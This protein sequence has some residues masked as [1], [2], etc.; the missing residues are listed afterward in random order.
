MRNV[1]EFIRRNWIR[2][3]V[4]LA[5]G[6]L[7]LLANLI[8]QT[9]NGSWSHLVFY[10]DGTF[11]GGA[12][13]I[14]FSLL[15]V[16]NIFGAFDIFSY[17]FARKRLE[18]GRKEDLYEYS[19]RKKEQRS[20]HKLVFLPYLSVGMSFLLISLILYFILKIKA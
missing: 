12:V 2:F 6:L 18:D 4:A 11:I 15:V 10:V 20:K 5:L 9:G 14:L 1:F 3:V 19:T 13:L 8:I 16:V 17:M 7:V